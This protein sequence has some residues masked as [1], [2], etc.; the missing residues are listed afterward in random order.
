MGQLDELQERHLR[1]VRLARAQLQ[2]PR[3]AARP[4]R[5]ARCDLLEELVDG[6]LVLAERGQR[7]AAGVEVAT[8]RQGDQLLDLGLDSLGLGHGRL[9]PLV[10]DEL[11][12]EV[13]EQ[14][15]AVRRVAPELV[16]VLLV[17]HRAK[18][19]RRYAARS[20]SPR[21]FSVSMTSSIDLRP[22]FGI[23]ASSDSDFC[24]RSPTV[25]TPARLR[26]L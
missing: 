3:V 5:V 26:Q 14:R 20:S 6:E 25:C 1:G 7:L 18:D 19:T 12:R 24:S 11:L 10:L 13:R 22:K 23:A 17:A 16:P 9:D 4:L 15:L 2:D 8:P 21:D